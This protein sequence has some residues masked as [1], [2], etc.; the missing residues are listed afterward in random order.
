MDISWIPV[1]GSNMVASAAAYDAYKK[2]EGDRVVGNIATGLEK[3]GEALFD[4]SMFQGLQRL[5]GTGNSY[6]SDRGIVG[7]AGETIKSGLGQAIPSL[8]RQIAQVKDPYQRD[9][10]NSNKGVSF[11]RMDNY[12]I[13]SLANN[14]PDVREKYLAPKV[15]TQG[16]LMMENQGRGIGYKVLEDMILPGKLTEIKSDALNDEAQR[17]AEANHS[18]KAF[19]PKADRKVVDQEA[20]EENEG[21][22]LTNEEWVDYQQKYYKALNDA[23]L[24]LIDSDYYKGLNDTEKEAILD[25]TYRAIR[26][27]VNSE[28][29][30][31]ELDGASKAYIEAG[32]GEKGSKAVINYYTAKSYV[33]K[34]GTTMSSKTGESIKAAIGRNDYEAAEKLAD[35]NA[36]Y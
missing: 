10:T 14:L 34:A 30:G 35:N 8:A 29:T 32:G 16:N 26:A 4:Q 12:N 9:V 21:H 18:N 23:G 36:T 27:A 2:G 20:S 31:K 7:N 3:G 19:I 15:D 1:L 22:I 5:F 25:N 28:Y 33:E 24:K 13:N 11:G 6:D 17:L